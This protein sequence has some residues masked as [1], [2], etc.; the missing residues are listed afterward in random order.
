MKHISFATSADIG[1]LADIERSASKKFI[2]TAKEDSY[3][4]GRTVPHDVLVSAQEK[5]HLWVARDQD[6]IVGFLVGMPVDNGFHIE[7]LSVDFRQQGK[8]YGRD[9]L[10]AAIE[11]AR[12]FGYKC[13]TL[14]TD[15]ELPWNAPFYARHGFVEIQVEDCPD[16]LRQIL[17]HDKETNPNPETR[18]AM[19]LRF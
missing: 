19:I 14:T 5:D 2:G 15:S 3:T 10:L 7:E 16:H 8:G 1:F 6:V 17:Q 18:I 9:L 11:S 12:A 4:N 13:V